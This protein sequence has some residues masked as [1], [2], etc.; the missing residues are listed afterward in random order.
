MSLNKSSVTHNYTVVSSVCLINKLNISGDGCSDSPI[1]FLV[2]K[3]VA[4]WVVVE[5]VFNPS[6]GSLG[7]GGGPE[8][9][10][11]LSSRPA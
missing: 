1:S 9:K 8:A 4:R 6:T 11:S 3:P 10:E 7:G 2:R 5:Q